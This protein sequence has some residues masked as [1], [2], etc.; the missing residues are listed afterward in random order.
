ML[1]FPTIAFLAFTSPLVEAHGPHVARQ[2][3]SLDQAVRP[4]DGF[5]FDEADDDGVAEST[6]AEATCTAGTG[7]SEEREQNE[8]RGLNHLKERWE[9][10][11]R[12]QDTNSNALDASSAA[13]VAQTT[14]NRASNQPASNEPAS[15]AQEST[16][17]ESEASTAAKVSTKDTQPSSAS[18]V[19]TT[20][21]S[22]SIA[23]TESIESTSVESSISTEQSSRSTST[24]STSQ[25]S[26]EPG[27][28]CFSTTTKFTTFCSTTF[29]G[30]RTHTHTC[31]DVNITSS[32]CSPGLLCATEPSSG[33][34]VCMEAHN[35]LGVPGIVIASFF[36]FTGLGC[37]ATMMYMCYKDKTAYKRGKNWK[38]PKTSETSRLL[39]EGTGTAAEVTGTSI[40]T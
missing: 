26:T 36:G 17:K 33:N 23:P 22:V 3:P 6:L 10:W 13:E 28:S 1:I 21:Q 24:T 19:L 38:A 11:V 9:Q 32:R 16:R 8:L 14:D 5:A 15:N 37:V 27:A 35:E 4:D 34:D 30:G 2:V 12:R 39:P 7:L 25:T 31:F 18:V 29:S 20:E 40:T